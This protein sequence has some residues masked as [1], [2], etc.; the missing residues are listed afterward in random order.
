MSMKDTVHAI[1]PSAASSLL[2]LGKSLTLWTRPYLQQNAQSVNTA[3]WSGAPDVVIVRG[4]AV[5]RFILER[6]QIYRSPFILFLK[7]YTTLGY[8]VSLILLNL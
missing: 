5:K 3:V 4:R 7:I 2:P 6:S 1:V 8:I